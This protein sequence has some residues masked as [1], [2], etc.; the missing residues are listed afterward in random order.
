MNQNVVHKGVRS[1]YSYHTGE[2][3]Q[4]IVV[5]LKF[6]IIKLFFKE[7]SNR[8]RK[9]NDLR[10]KRFLTIKEIHLIIFIQRQNINTALS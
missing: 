4:S 10:G 8:K 9:R 3:D 2:Y 5:S 7:Y 1:N 6:R